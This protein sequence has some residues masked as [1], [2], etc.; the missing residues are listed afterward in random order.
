MS[1]EEK[2][3]LMKRAIFFLAMVLLTA[4]TIA[5]TSG[6][7]SAATCNGTFTGLTPN[8][9]NGQSLVAANGNCTMCHGAPTG[10]SAA[11][12][13]SWASN[14]SFMSTWTC[15]N[16]VDVAAALA[17]ATA[18]CTSFTYSAWGTCQ[19]NGTQTRTVTSSSPTGCTGG[20]PVLSQSCTYVPPV[21][22]CT[23]F[24]Y[25]AWGACQSNNTQTRTVTS[26]SP[27]GCTGGSPVLSQT[28]TYTPPA[29]AC[30]SYTYTL[31]V[32]QPNG[33]APVLSYVGIPS[34]C[35]GGVMP[36]TMQPCTYI[37][38]QTPG[39]LMQPAT[40]GLYWDDVNKRLGIGT[41]YPNVTLHVSEANGANPDRGIVNAQH[42]DYSSAAAFQFFKSRGTENA[43]TALPNGDAIGAIHYW[44]FD[45]TNYEAVASIRAMVSAN[46]TVQTGSIPG[47][48]W[49]HTGSNST[50]TWGAPKMVIN[51]AGNVGIG[52]S[53]PTQTLEVNGGM[54]MNTTA[55]QPSC[56]AGARGTLW[57]AQSASGD[58][59]QVCILSGGSYVWRTIAN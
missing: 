13:Y 56:G 27:S 10:A 23:S 15:Q 9:A 47:E 14:M 46:G 39:M 17:P 22:T 8:L 54:R 41:S 57:V 5:G 20:T 12:I 48:L 33:M 34:G 26:S 29:T 49:F 1:K 31:G 44:A 28:C 51:T 4:A 58:T 24:T 11:T 19:S 36:A 7:A 38:S 37:P 59:V 21:T 53:T 52:T 6:N 32:C 42:S 3:D 2:G 18:T 45:G 25:S 50:A 43:P 30:T 40:S 55:T 16:F 35:S